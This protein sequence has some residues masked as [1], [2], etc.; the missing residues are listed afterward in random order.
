MLL[1][2]INS[3]YLIDYWE[4]SNVNITFA[5]LQSTI[6]IYPLLKPTYNISPMS[7]SKFTQQ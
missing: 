5:S 2:F 1:S 7:F 3:N 4:Q 6:C